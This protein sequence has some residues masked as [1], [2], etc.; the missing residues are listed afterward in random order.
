MEGGAVPE[1]D[2]AVAAVLADM[3]AAGLPA[4][5]TMTA[6]AARLANAERNAY[7]NQEPPPVAEVQ[8]LE[9]PGPRR[10]LPARLYR[11]RPGTL[12]AILFLHGG[13]WLFGS[14]ETHDNVARRLALASA[15]PVLSLDYGL[16]PE[17]PYPAGLEDVLAAVAYLRARDAALGLDGA[18]LALAGDSAGANLALAACLRLR[19][20]GLPQPAAAALIYGAFTPSDASLSHAAFGGGDFVLSTAAMR[21]FWDH[22]LPDRACRQDPYAA[23]LHAALH[24]LPPLLII[25]AELDPLRCDSEELAMRAIAAGQAVDYRLWRGMTHASLNWSRRVP[26]VQGLIAEIGSFLARQL[27]GAP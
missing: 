16:A 20:T 11:P 3:A 24:G 27:G 21:W 12:P 26:R 10:P 4:Y 19:D 15:L 1:L 5:E 8:D 25:A 17:E 22:Y 23:P 18:A 14:I 13:G 6:V 2:P 9:L 7:W